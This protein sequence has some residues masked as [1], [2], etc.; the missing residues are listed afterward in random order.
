MNPLDLLTEEGRGHFSERF[1][2]MQAG[3]PVP[4]TV[5]YAIRTQDG[6][7]LWVLLNTRLSYEGQTLKGATVVAHNI[8][9]RR[10]AN[11]QMQRLLD[12]QIAINR[13]SL[14]LGETRDLT[15]IYR[16]IYEHVR[17]LMDADAF[18]VSFYE[19]ERELL[20]AGYVI[21]GDVERDVTP[22]PPIPLEAEGHGTQSRVI[23]TG[24]PFY[25]PD[26]R[27]IMAA[28]KTEHTIEE[29]GSLA[30]GP[31][32]AERKEESTNS[33]LMVPMKIVGE[34][35]GVMQVQSHRLDA[36]S[37]ADTNLLSG[38]ANVAALAIEN[39]RLL[40]ASRQQAEQLEALRR[41]S[42]ELTILRNSDT[43]LTQ[44]A[45]QAI[46]LLGVDGGGVYLYRPEQD[47]L[48]WVVQVGGPA[49]KIGL[50]LRRGEG[51]SGKV[52][53]AGET[54]IVDDYHSW[55]DRA[56]GWADF[57]AQATMSVPI[58]GG[59]EMLGVLNV[60]S[61]KTGH[62]SDKDVALLSQFAAQAAIAIQNARLYEDE[63]ISRERAEA[64]RRAAQAMGASLE[65]DASLR[66]ILQQ[67]KRVIVFD[68]AS[69]LILRKDNKPDLV[70]GVGYSDERMTS[71]ESRRLLESS[72]ILAQMS[73]DLA[74]VVSGDVRELD[75]WIWVPG[76]EHVRSW[77][78]VP[79]V[80]RDRMIGALMVDNAATDFFSA[81]DIEITQALAQH[82]AQVIEKA[83]LFEDL[84]RHAER[85]E[86]RVAERTRDL[87]AANERLKELDRLKSKFVSDV[88]HELR[89]P[90]T[91]IKLYLHLLGHDDAE[92]WS[93]H[94]SVLEKESDRLAR[95]I[96]DILNLSR[97]DL[98][99]DKMEPVPVDLNQIVGQV[100]MAHLPRAEVAGLRLSFEPEETL[101]P[102]WG[103]PSQLAQVITNL[104]TN[105]IN[106]T[107]AGYVRVQTGRASVDG[108]ACLEVEDTGIGIEPEDRPHLFERFYRGK[109]VGSS[110]IPGTGL[111]LA[112]VKEIVDLH[113]GRIEVQSRPDQGSRFK[114]CLPLAASEKEGEEA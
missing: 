92:N 30:P 57:P 35:I 109:R 100:V 39:A 90:I 73:R 53:A 83:R 15:K 29:N 95:L 89:T 113:G 91:N 5:E 71:H 76:A 7:E 84:Q 45:E 61:E 63:R 94:L 54:I 81:E 112:I 67:L 68:T 21:A 107:P 10:R 72:P 58:Q 60:W 49:A 105:A 114:I 87:A 85:L 40:N 48:E 43:L 47:V 102:V 106:Y 55:S 32:P 75:G 56:T 38:L 110:N 96:E 74:P 80:A 3:E 12:Q 24:Q 31:P 66:L 99:R 33:A 70:V 103:E 88:S 62:F 37:Q 108:R 22:F 8:T 17:E 42:Q 104:V 44:I 6:R 18:I 4:E 23:H 20:H 41:V 19:R 2:K 59:G 36:Y 26:Y 13:L 93:G 97:L 77:M 101:P 64:L 78:G 65:L 79:L 16:I 34:T 14:A 1:L 111:G 82:A 27:Q 11:E 25:A 69:L 50:T 51:L 28:T 98:A 9:A 46:E 52:M 86:E